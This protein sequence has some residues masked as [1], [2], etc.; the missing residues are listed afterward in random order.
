MADKGGCKKRVCYIAPF[1]KDNFWNKNALGFCVQWV[2]WGEEQWLIPWRAWH[3]PSLFH[4][5]VQHGI[6]LESYKGATE[7]DVEKSL[8]PGFST[9][10]GGRICSEI[11]LLLYALKHEDACSLGFYCSGLN[12]M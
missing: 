1:L 4:W 9:D 12:L 7:S 5:R 3:T 11:G 6:R 8:S 2:H 10:L